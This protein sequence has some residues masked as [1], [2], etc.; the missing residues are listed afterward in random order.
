[1]T[2]ARK[3]QRCFTSGGAVSSTAPASTQLLTAPSDL[4][5]G[6]ARAGRMVYGGTSAASSRFLPQQRRQFGFAR[7]FSNRNLVSASLLHDNRRAIPQRTLFR[8][9]SINE[10]K[11]S[12]FHGGTGS[13]ARTSHSFLPTAGLDSGFL[14]G[15]QKRFTHASMGTA[16]SPLPEGYP[17]AIISR[18]QTRSPLAR[19]NEL[20]TIEKQLEKLGG[21]RPAAVPHSLPLVPQED[22]IALPHMYDPAQ[23]QRYTPP[24]HFRSYRSEKFDITKKTKEKRWM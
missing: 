8:G 24:A 16:V 7:A 2:I 1:M 15:T 22:A 6:A 12:S 21:K 3:V 20:V 14:G 4:G 17:G 11:L 23:V 10:S 5:L 13:E 18:H 9:A 19:L